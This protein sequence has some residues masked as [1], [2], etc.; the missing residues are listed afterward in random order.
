MSPRLD[1]AELSQR[2]KNQAADLMLQIAVL[3]QGGVLSAAAFSVIGIFQTEDA[4]WIRLIL[5]LTS[6]IIGLLMFFRLC[7]RALYLMKAGL[8]VLFVG[9]L[10]CLFQIIPFA[11]LSSTALGDAGWRY[12]Y[13][14][15]TL[16]FAFGLG[17]N[18]LSLRTLTA[19]QYAEDAAH[20]FTA[21]YASIRQQCFEGVAALLLTLTLT[22]W[23]LAMPPDWPYATAF[24]SVHLAL[25]VISGILI[26]RQDTRDMNAL[27]ASLSD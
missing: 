20:V 8:E 7:H 16:V 6:V 13:V 26:I 14:A 18:W 9:P 24:V 1:R 11:V 22:L 25:T 4:T 10:M 5:W 21:L 27:R 17:A 2:I 15:D 3:L 12:W 19:D 23:I